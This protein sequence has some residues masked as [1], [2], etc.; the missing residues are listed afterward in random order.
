[1]KPF[2]ALRRIYDR[3][4]R[5]ILY[6]FF[7]GLTTLVDFAI[8]FALNGLLFKGRGEAFAA[9]ANAAAWCGAVVFAFVTNKL[10]V[11]ESKDRAGKTV[12]RE[13]LSFTAARV[14]TLLLSTGMIYFGSVLFNWDE[15]ILKIASSVVVIVLN[16]VF[17][18]LFIFKR[19]EDDRAK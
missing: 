2:S 19:K 18:R 16:Y 1:M 6:L 8:F 9:A 7:G 14:V 13:F 11:F 12:M 5:E 10:F 3:Y 4:K 15:N 17:S